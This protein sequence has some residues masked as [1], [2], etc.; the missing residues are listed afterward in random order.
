MIQIEYTLLNFYCNEKQI[1][2]HKDYSTEKL[3]VL[4]VINGICEIEN[5]KNMFECKFKT[6]IKSGGLC[7]E[8]FYKKRSEITKKTIV[9][10]PAPTAAPAKP[11]EEDSW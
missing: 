1:V 5:C 11:K 6:L 8:C 2:L 10:K 7:K 3:G 9:E 4:S